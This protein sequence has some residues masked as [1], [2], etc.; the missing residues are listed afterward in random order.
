M[1]RLYGCRGD[2]NAMAAGFSA[3]E[4]RTALNLART[5]TGHSMVDDGRWVVL[6][7]AASSRY[8]FQLGSQ[9]GYESLARSDRQALVPRC[10]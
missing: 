2:Y 10:E 6:A 5:A 9:P 8:L 3:A 7:D 4:A 1:I